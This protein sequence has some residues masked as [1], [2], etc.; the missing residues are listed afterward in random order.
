MRFHHGLGD[1]AYFAHLIPLYE[2]RGHH[3]EVE[4]TPDKRVLFDA[5]DT[6]LLVLPA[7]AGTLGELTFDRARMA[8][9]LSSTMMATI[10]LAKREPIE[11]GR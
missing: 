4:C 8:A 7:V 11:C 6:M 2:K 10:S 1:C 5:V 3:I 9:A